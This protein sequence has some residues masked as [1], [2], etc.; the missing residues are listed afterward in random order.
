MMKIVSTQLKVVCSSFQFPLSVTR[1]YS[2]I[3]CSLAQ[4]SEDIEFLYNDLTINTPFSMCRF[5]LALIKKELCNG[6][7]VLSPLQYRIIKKENFTQFLYD[8][9]PDCPDMML[10]TGEDPDTAYV[11]M[12]DKSDVLVFM[13]LSLMLYRLYNGGLPKDGGYRINDQRNVVY[14]RVQ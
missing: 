11:L 13:G 3:E 5:E 1:N 7:Y 8:M 9:L 14:K 12:P 2:T 4:L 10:G 6:F